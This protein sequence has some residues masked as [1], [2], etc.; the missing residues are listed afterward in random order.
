VILWLILYWSQVDN[1]ILNRP[2]AAG[3][4][5]RSASKGMNG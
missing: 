3:E 4:L 5:G 1:Q 2:I